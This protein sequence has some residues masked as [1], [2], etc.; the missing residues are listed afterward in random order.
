MSTILQALKKAEQ[1]SGADRNASEPNPQV[2][3]GSR[4]RAGA[5]SQV[6]TQAKVLH[7]L[8]AAGIIGVCLAAA[9]VYFIWPGPVSTPVVTPLDPAATLTVEKRPEPQKIP[10]PPPA[11]VLSSQPFDPKTASVPVQKVR[12]KPARV[13]APEKHPEAVSIQTLDSDVMKLQAISW[14]KN[15]A[16]RIAVIND[17]VLGEK[18]WIDGYEILNINKDEIILSDSASKKYRLAFRKR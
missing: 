11:P 13:S 9:G 6:E 18:E 2:M 15:P 1:A 12:K 8:I 7:R 14:S 16:Q 10:G 5:S 17:R 3:G 4:G